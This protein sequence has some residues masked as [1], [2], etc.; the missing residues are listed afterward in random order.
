MVRKPPV[1]VCLKSLEERKLENEKYR[2]VHGVYT[3]ARPIYITIKLLSTCQILPAN[4]LL[5][6]IQLLRML[7]VVGGELCFLEALQVLEAQELMEMMC[8]VR[9]CMLEVVEGKFCLL[10][11]HVSKLEAV[12]VSSVCWRYRW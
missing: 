7:E 4:K 9:L 12:E 8:C 1:A 11:A 6:T 2:A 5:P 10:K 3:R